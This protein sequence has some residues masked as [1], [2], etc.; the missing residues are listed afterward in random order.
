[1]AK[2]GHRTLNWFE[3]IVNRM[4]GEERAERFCRDEL[5]LVESERK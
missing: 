5:I 2:Y 1:M 3:D 4:G